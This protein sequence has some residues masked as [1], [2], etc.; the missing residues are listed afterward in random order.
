MELQFD[1]ANLDIDVKKDVDDKKGGAGSALSLFKCC[2]VWVGV[3]GNREIVSLGRGRESM[4]IL[5]VLEQ[6]EKK[7]NEPKPTSV[8]DFECC[9]GEGEDH[10]DPKRN[11]K[12]KDKCRRLFRQAQQKA[13][14]SNR[15]LTQLVC[16]AR[17]A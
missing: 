11:V 3:R 10:S 17:L 16:C 13:K 14:K 4:E 8:N 15:S 12:T 2:I 7:K 5:E 6:A 9:F 1:G